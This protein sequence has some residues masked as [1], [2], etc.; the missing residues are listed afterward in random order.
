MVNKSEVWG[1]V[2]ENLKTKERLKPM[3]V[4]ARSY[5]EAIEIAYDSEPPL[6][7]DNYR[8]V[9]VER[10]VDVVVKEVS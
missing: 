1:V 7:R 9:K 6:S 8:V 2:L 4:V 3:S 5:G 10:L